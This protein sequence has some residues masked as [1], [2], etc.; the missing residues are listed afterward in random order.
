MYPFYYLWRFVGQ[1]YKRTHVLS[2]GTKTERHDTHHHVSASQHLW[3]IMKAVRRKF[4]SV[5]LQ[6][7]FSGNTLRDVLTHS[8]ALWDWGSGMK[9]L[10]HNQSPWGA[11][12]IYHKWFK[13]A[14]LPP[15]KQ[16][17]HQGTQ[18]DI[19][20]KYTLSSAAWLK[21]NL[22]GLNFKSAQRKTGKG[23]FFFF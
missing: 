9:S 6:M 14:C 10:S 12:N 22:R 5:L 16:W 15:Q 3:H 13:M 2:T 21:Q 17:Y 1:N 4:L 23:C 7:W 19:T 18:T 11:E 20:D 8:E